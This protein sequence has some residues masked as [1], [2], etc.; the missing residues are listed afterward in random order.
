MEHSRQPIKV[1]VIGAGMA[2]LACASKLKQAGLVVDIFDKGL[3]TGGRLAS[4]T[5]DA[6]Q[7]DYGAQFFTI[8]DNHFSDFLAPCIDK[9]RV[10]PWEARFGKLVPGLGF[11]LDTS[12]KERFVAVPAMR[13][14]AEYI[15]EDHELSVRTG[16]LVSSLV[17]DEDIL[18][19]DELSGRRKWSLKVQ[20]PAGSQPEA[21]VGSKY[22]LVV[23]AIPPEQARKLWPFATLE[24]ISFHPCIAAMFSFAE[25]VQVFPEYGDQCL[26]AVVAQ[27]EVFSWIARDSSKPGRPTGERW[28]LHCSPQW[29]AS[30][31]NEEKDDLS[32]FLLRSFGDI[33]GTNLPE[34]LFS[35]IHLWRY[36]LCERSSGEGFIW[37]EEKGIGF[38]G[39]WLEN[40]RLEG[41]FMSGNALAEKIV[42]GFA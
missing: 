42:S 18:A 14:L 16:V 32:K 22:D 4:R 39:D 3:F 33:S 36:A 13:S 41:A 34:V 2:G 23:I 11:Q 5:S 31:F 30:H 24:S 40:P 8:R 19:S 15:V 9:G 28:V 1:A 21:T 7:F 38:C 37:L 17:Y 29:S 35:K 10:R 12:D 26:D 20:Q 25:A 6:N 27:H